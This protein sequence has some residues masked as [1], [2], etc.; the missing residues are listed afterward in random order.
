V[1]AGEAPPSGS[2]LEL[3][4]R[5]MEVKAIIRAGA[6]LDERALDAHASARGK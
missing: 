4:C 3:L 2:A 1:S 6:L 5:Y